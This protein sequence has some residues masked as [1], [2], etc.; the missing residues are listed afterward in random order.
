MVVADEW[1]DLALE[2]AA[3]PIAVANPQAYLEQAPCPVAWHSF[4]SSLSYCIVYIL[5]LG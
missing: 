4:F 1:L 3:T 5:G 2:E